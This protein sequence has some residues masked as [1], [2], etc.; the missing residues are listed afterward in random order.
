M[1]PAFHIR[2]KAS[3]PQHRPEAEGLEMQ[4]QAAPP[5]HNPRVER[6]TC[7]NGSAVKNPPAT[8][9]TQERGL[10]LWLGKTP[11]GRKWQPAQCILAWEMPWLEE[12]GGRQSVGL[13]TIRHAERRS[14][15]QSRLAALGF[16][17]RGPGCNPWSGK[18]D[19][20]S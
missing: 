6:G 10:D 8:Q 9:E 12:P 3:I 16:H 19:A 11:C 5:R 13:K 7:R 2:W 1:H 18:S 17:C 4:F 20:T 14:T 15:E